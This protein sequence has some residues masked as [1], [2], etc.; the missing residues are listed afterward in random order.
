MQIRHE[1]MKVELDQRMDAVR[2]AM[3]VCV[4]EGIRRRQL[5]IAQRY[6][7]YMVR[8]DAIREELFELL[9][10]ENRLLSIEYDELLKCE[11]TFV[12]LHYEQYQ[13][14]IKFLVTLLRD[15]AILESNTP[16]A[17]AVEFDQLEKELIEQLDRNRDIWDE[18]VDCLREKYMYDVWEIERL[19]AAGQVHDACNMMADFLATKPLTVT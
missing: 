8:F 13:R 14:V 15:T 5:K 3:S 1:R 2:D 10:E 12:D 7:E 4:Q 19:I 16:L 6:K 18:A 17:V 9:K 11:Y